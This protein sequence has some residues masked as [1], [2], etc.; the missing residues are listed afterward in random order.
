MLDEA[1]FQ[2]YRRCAPVLLK[3]VNIEEPPAGPP[4]CRPQCVPR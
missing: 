2:F 3:S 1:W 4:A